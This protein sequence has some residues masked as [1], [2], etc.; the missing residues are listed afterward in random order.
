MHIRNVLHSESLRP[1]RQLD[2][3]P[4]VFFIDEL[5]RCKTVS[6]HLQISV[7]TNSKHYC[8]VEGISLCIN[9][10][11][12]VSHRVNVAASQYGVPVASSWIGKFVHRWYALPPVTRFDV[13][14]GSW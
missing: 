6:L 8:N 5:D 3:P 14:S 9:D 13:I 4:L 7:G 2:T 10:Q 11:Q 1:L 12:E